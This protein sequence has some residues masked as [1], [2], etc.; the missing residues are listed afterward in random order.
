LTLSHLSYCKNRTTATVAGEFEINVERSRYGDF[1][2]NSSEPSFPSFV[3]GLSRG[4]TKKRTGK[5]SV[6]TNG[7]PGKTIIIYVP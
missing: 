4:V 7:K 6:Q 5:R 2:V 3:C 1:V